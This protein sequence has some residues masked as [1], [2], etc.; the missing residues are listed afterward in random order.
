MTQS[1]ENPR[2]LAQLALGM[3]AGVVAMGVSACS[4]EYPKCDQDE[5]CHKGEFC[6]NNLC[7]QCRGNNDCPA[8]QQCAAGAC[9]AVP[10]YC[11]SASQCGPGEDCVNN[12]CVTQAQSN[13][14]QSTPEAPVAAGQCEFTPVYFDFD[15]D[16]LADSARDQLARNASCVKERTVKALHLTGL[17]DPRGT[18]EYNLALGDRRAKS[19]Q[20]YLKSL[21]IEAEVSYSSM[22]EELAAGSDEG[23]WAKDRRVDFRT[24]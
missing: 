20:Q 11:T 23:G 16:A 12:T 18:E 6:V 15:S 14:D 9:Q 1:S 24:K 13:L 19:A 8:G 3:L 17:T 4:P 2:S 21:G 10:G 5:D 7:Q 22:G